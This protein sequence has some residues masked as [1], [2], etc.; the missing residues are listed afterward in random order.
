MT[1][2]LRSPDRDVA[3]LMTVAHSW[4]IHGTDERQRGRQLDVGDGGGAANTNALTRRLSVPPDGWA[5]TARRQLATATALPRLR[6]MALP[7]LR[8]AVNSCP[9]VDLGQVAGR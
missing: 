5:V 3:P 2:G 6:V 7:R 9:S 4:S 1:G 8:T